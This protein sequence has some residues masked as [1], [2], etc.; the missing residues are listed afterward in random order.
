MSGRPRRATRSA[1]R[2]ET[3]SPSKKVIPTTILQPGTSSSKPKI[4]PDLNIQYLLHNPKSALTRLDLSVRAAAVAQRSII[5]D[6]LCMQKVLNYDT[7]LLLDEE[8][9]AELATLLP[10]TAFV[11]YGSGRPDSTHPSQAG[12]SSTAQDAGLA[13]DTAAAQQIDPAVFKDSHFIA[14][15]KTFQDH[16]YSGWRTEAHA[17]KIEKYTAGVRDGSLAAPWKDV[18]WEREH[19]PSPAAK[20]ASTAQ[21]T[22]SAWGQAGDRDDLAG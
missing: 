13:S 16:L 3:S 8:D 5:S 2:T 10:P 9:R 14:A 21:R 15:S 17:S 7:W 19:A 4:T 1:A 12:Q 18:V 6:D 20:P 22:V 11:G